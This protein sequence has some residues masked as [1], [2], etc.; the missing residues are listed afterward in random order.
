[1]TSLGSS[2]ERAASARSTP[3]RVALLKRYCHDGIEFPAFSE[4]GMAILPREPVRVGHAWRPPPQAVAEWI[5]AAGPGPA[6]PVECLL[7]SVEAGVALVEVTVRGHVAV[8]GRKVRVPTKKTLRIDT[9]SGRRVGR[10]TA[11]QMALKLPARGAVPAE[12]VESSSE[13]QESVAFSPGAGRAASRPADGVDLGWPPPPKDT[14]SYQHPGRAF[15][16]AV[17]RGYAAAAVPPDPSVLAMFVN[18]R[19]FNITVTR[20]LT[21]RLWDADEYVRRFEREVL[22]GLPDFETIRREDLRLTG[23]VPAVLLISKVQRGRR[24]MLTMI[25]LDGRRITTVSAAV[26]ATAASLQEE[27]LRSLQTLRVVAAG[28]GARAT[29]RPAG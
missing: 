26:P 6:P 12:T 18:R 24:V 23:N 8:G 5:G 1:M 21:R 20:D 11:T 29:T 3:P 16:L 7:A 2:S 27:L 19:N 13:T 9:A 15:S 17:P 22:T 4:A 28:G 25:A 14:N 10:T